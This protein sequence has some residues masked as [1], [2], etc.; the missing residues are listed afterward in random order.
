MLRITSAQDN[1]PVRLAPQPDLSG[2]VPGEVDHVEAGG[3]VLAIPRTAL[4]R[5]RVLPPSRTQTVD[6]VILVLLW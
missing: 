5:M 6:D 2:R 4:D 1:A 3:H